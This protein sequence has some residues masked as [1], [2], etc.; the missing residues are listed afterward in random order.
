MN[1]NFLAT[2]LTN[3]EEPMEQHPAA[4]DL[5]RNQGR[6]VNIL[7]SGRPQSIL[8]PGGR[9]QG[10]STRRARQLPSS[11]QQPRDSDDDDGDG[12]ANL[13]QL[14]NDENDDSENQSDDED[15][16][17]DDSRIE[18]IQRIPTAA[19]PARGTIGTAAVRGAPFALGGVTPGSEGVSPGSGTARNGCARNGSSASTPP[20]L[21]TG[22]AL[23]AAAEVLIQESPGDLLPTELAWQRQSAGDTAQVRAFRSEVLQRSDLVVFGYMRPASP[24]IHLLH[25]VGTFT[26]HGG[27]E[28]YRGKDIAFV[29]DKTEYASP[30]PVLLAPEQPWRWITKKLPMDSG[31][32]ELFYA[33]PQN[34]AKL[35][36]PANRTGEQNITLPRLIVIPTQFI[37]FCVKG[38]RTPFQLHQHVVSVVTTDGSAVSMA[39]CQFL[40]DWCVMASFHDTHHHTSIMAF[41]LEAAISTDEIFNKWLQRRLRFMIGRGSTQPPLLPHQGPLPGNPQQFLTFPAP[42]GAPPAVTPV[43]PP[44]LWAHFAASLTQ[45]ITAAMQPTASALA[46]SSGGVASA[47]EEGGRYYDKYQLAILRGFSHC[48]ALQGIQQI[49]ALFQT[50]KHADTHKNNLL[51]KM[52]RWADAQRPPVSIDR[53]LYLTNSTL[54]DILS[55]KFNPG[56]TTADLSTAEQGMSILICHP[57]S[58]ESKAAQR[59]RELIEGKTSKTSLSLDDATRLVTSMEPTVCPEDYHSLAKCLGTYCALLHTLFGSRCRFYIDCRGLLNVLLS[60]RVSEKPHAFTPLF[61][62]QLVWAIIEEGRAYFSQQLTLEDF[63]GL[64]PDNIEYPECT[65][66]ELQPH[67]RNQ[68]PIFRSSFPALWNVV[69]HETPL[70]QAQFGSSLAPPVPTIQTFTPSVISGVSGQS[71]STTQTQRQAPPVTIRAN[72]HPIIKTAL[73]A[74]VQRFWSI[75]LTQLLA[76]LNLTLADLP[77][78]PGMT[79]DTTLCYNY[80]LGR[81]VHAGCNHKHAAVDEVTDEFA[82][83]LIT[84]LR[85]AVQSFMTNGAPAQ[86]FRCKRKQRSE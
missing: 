49:W 53:N 26:L 81:C 16:G 71:Q 21:A 36:Q 59:Q 46:A 79:G 48:H 42:L 37:K 69:T 50:T 35:Y 15:S 40:L 4:Q 56:N 2:H 62:R 17:D 75:C 52:A 67:V 78:L 68:S 12:N 76:S 30:T 18:I 80:V 13:L 24:Y 34:K 9:D 60:N 65:L 8:S 33:A 74:Y 41:G 3:D 47:Y 1:V 22:S 86:P 55:L 10:I 54:K 83:R 14:G 44:D 29:G 6:R 27:D 77:T 84:I 85:P 5:P 38:Q 43:P 32:L 63:V 11:S 70:P 19:V 72:T 23:A 58:S 57:R 66:A 73:G 31:P 45:G 25:T 28:H 64:H 20:P 39:Q 51:R 61:C 7:E 82:T